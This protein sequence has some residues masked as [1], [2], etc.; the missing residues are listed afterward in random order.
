MTNK[1]NKEKRQKI[2]FNI[3]L[4]TIILLF[5]SSLYFKNYKISF[6]I[7]KGIIV[8]A[9]VIL[10]LNIY[11]L[12]D[13]KIFSSNSFILIATLTLNVIYDIVHKKYLANIIKS[14]VK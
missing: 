12:E 2:M 8:N 10:L 13:K 14:L 3:L 9:L 7:L 1:S 4:T 6:Y 5:I 11:N